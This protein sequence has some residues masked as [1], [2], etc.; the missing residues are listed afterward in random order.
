MPLL[1][2]ATNHNRLACQSAA[3]SP[4]YPQSRCELSDFLL[5]SRPIS[6]RVPHHG[7]QPR[8]KFARPC[9]LNSLTN[10]SRVQPAAR[11]HDQSLARN[12]N[13]LAKHLQRL[14]GRPSS[15]RGQQPSRP[16]GD[17]VLHGPAQIGAL[18]KRAMKGHR[19]RFCGLDESHSAPDIDPP[20]RIDQTHNNPI[21]PGLFRCSNF[22]LHGRELSIRIKEVSAA[23]AN[24][25]KNRQTHAL[26]HCPQQLGARRCAPFPRIAA[27]LNA[28][29]TPALRRDR[30][31][32]ALHADF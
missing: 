19:E 2:R 31:F 32:D 18:I 23:R 10:I 3:M 6:C 5:K 25:G 22:A 15:S 9:L 29:R 8:V 11:H 7:T 17:D 20:I 27:K 1:F 28:L 12:S 30:R 13:K 24:H 4:A 16:R 14:G 21:H 26:A